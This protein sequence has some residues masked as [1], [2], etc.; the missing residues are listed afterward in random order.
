MTW[1]APA[2]TGSSVHRGRRDDQIKLRGYRIEL[3][4]IET[5]IARTPGVRQ[6]AV[7]LRADRL[8]DPRLVA[9]VK[10]RHPVKISPPVKCACT[11]A[12]SCR[13]T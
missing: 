8:G 3:G 11:C 13:N 4:E 6:C 10:Y 1:F 5:T 9:Y 7:A 12:A 2:P